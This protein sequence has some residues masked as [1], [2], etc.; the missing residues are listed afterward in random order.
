MNAKIATMLPVTGVLAMA[1]SG[2][3]WADSSAAGEEYLASGE[4]AEPNVLFVID[5]SPDMAADCGTVLTGVAS[6]ETCFEVVKDAI[7]SVARHYDWARYG[8]V[9]TD[10]TSSTDDFYKIAPLGSSQAELSAALASV[11]TTTSAV[12]NV[13]E[14]IEAL[15]TE[16][17]DNTATPDGVDDD[18]D[19]IVADW[20]EAAI[21]YSCQETHIITI[22]IDWPRSDNQVTGGWKDSLGT[23]VTCN[24]AGKTTD[25]TDT[26]CLYDNV[27]HH[28]YNSDLISGLS[29][30]Q[31]ATVHTVGIGID[32]SSLAEELYGNASDQIGGAGVYTVAWSP[33]AVLA[34][35]IAVMTDIRQGTYSRSTPIVTSSGDYLIYSYYELTGDNPLAEGHI[36]GYEIETDPTDPDYG[37]I[38]YD[39]TSSFGGAVWDGGN[40]LVSRPVPGGERQ[41][42]DHDGVGWRDIYTFFDEASTITDFDAEN[43]RRMPFDSLFASAVSGDAGSFDKILDTTAYGSIT[44]VSGVGPFSEHDLDEDCDI[45]GND[46][47]MMVDFLRGRPDATFRYMD[48]ERGY[49]KLGDSPYGIP[50]V[51]EPRLDQAFSMEPSYRKFQALQMAADQPRMVFMAANDGMLHAFYLDDEPGT[52]HS[53]AGEEAWAWVPGYLLYRERDPSWTNSALDLMMYG[54]TFLF[55]GSPVVA[56]VWIDHDGDGAKECD[57]LGIGTGVWSDCE[58]HRVVVV[59][60]GKGGPLTM[61]LD[62]T[63][64]LD[65]KFL[66]EQYDADADAGLGYTSGRPIVTQIRDAETST[67]VRDR[68]VVMWASGRAVPFGEGGA[69]F[70]QNAEANLYMWDVAKEYYDS[71]DGWPSKTYDSRGDNDHPE[72]SLVADL[73]LDLRLEQAYI[74]AALAVIDVDSDGD[75]DTVY[76]PVSTTYTPTD[77][78]G[79]GPSTIANMGDPAYIKD[80]ASTYMYKA[81]IDTNDPDDLTW[82]EFYD[83]KDDGGLTV[84]PEVY[85]AATT[86]WHSDGS[87]GVYWGTGTPYDRSSS[88][89]GY[90]F[91]VRDTNPASCSSFTA[92]GISDCGANGVYPL[93]AGEGLTGDP[94][95]YAGTVY[96][97]TWVP[98][99]DICDGGKGRVYGISYQDCDPAM[100]T[101]GDGVVDGSDDPYIEEDGYTSGVSVT[102]Q[103]NLVYGV[104]NADMTDTSDLG[105]RD[106]LG[107]PFMGTAALAW[108]EV[109]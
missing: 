31:N 73:D 93:S 84:R 14:V 57:S 42:G 95:V 82:A 90:F 10:T 47:Q 81:C 41:P 86:S 50:A 72:S 71:Y 51:V 32:S 29:G 54:R 87:L 98:E 18:G 58:W 85:Y 68:Y 101:N 109:F 88:D 69:S 67:D 63:D 3:A 4:Y 99:A 106:A 15:G 97:S 45:D 20:S 23:D 64:P 75:A 5:R 60:Q 13:A 46:L 27:V 66:W 35:I 36:R 8:V 6:G 24:A 76:F 80:P 1:L 103:G 56:D 78:G 39:A 44:C 59:Q 61:A 89:L 91:A 33:D 74:G 28:I 105:F 102:D 49:W 34:G 19:G 26:L 79:A 53:E 92:D 2:T 37:Q 9:G 77:E 7:Q 43:E 62:I 83:P 21:E 22:T 108:M 17:L 104:H 38:L 96:F 52:A 40:L 100:D 65:P 94:L 55:D 70:F 107:D 30:T 16:Y 11:G 12:R 48:I 25:G